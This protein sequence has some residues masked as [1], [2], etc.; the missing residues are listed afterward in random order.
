MSQKLDVKM[1][2]IENKSIISNSFDD[3]EILKI[4]QRKNCKPKPQNQNPIEKDM[5]KS[6]SWSSK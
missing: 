5:L 1:Q 3:K 6:E 2:S 4:F